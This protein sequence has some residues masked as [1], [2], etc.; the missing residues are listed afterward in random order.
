M[1][2]HQIRQRKLFNAISEAVL[3]TYGRVSLSALEVIT[4]GAIEQIVLEQ[5][6]HENFMREQ[7]AKA[8]YAVADIADMV[9]SL[10]A[11]IGGAA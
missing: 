1:T 9:A 6:Y 7:A 3:T 4:A 2:G 8:G 10:H 11:P 5:A